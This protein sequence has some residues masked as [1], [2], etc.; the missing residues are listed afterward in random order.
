MDAGL[1][2]VIS[3]LVSAIVGLVVA[4]ANTPHVLQ[5]AREEVENRLEKLRASLA[6]ELRTHEARLRVAAE[7]RLQILQRQM[8]SVSSLRGHIGKISAALHKLAFAVQVHGAGEQ[9]GAARIEFDSALRSVSHGSGFV[10]PELAREAEV[11]LASLQDQM[12]AILGTAMLQPAERLA[13]LTALDRDNQA[14]AARSR[15]AFGT[16]QRELLQEH[17]K[18]LHTVEG[19]D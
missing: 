19:T 15:E 6:R 8:D 7:G 3:T 14:I 16:W 11:L 10:P 13:R 5:K 4:R 12:D 1:I 2:A 18:W 17:E 9:T